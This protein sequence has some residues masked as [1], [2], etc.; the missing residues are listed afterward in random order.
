MP[1]PNFRPARS[2]RSGKANPAIGFSN[3]EPLSA[4]LSIVSPDIAPAAKL[5][6]PPPAAP[7][8]AS[9]TLPPAT[10]T[11]PVG[12][13]VPIRESAPPASITAPLPVM[14]PAK[15]DAAVPATVSVWLPSTIALP[16]PPPR[17]PMI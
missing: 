17:P 12:P 5:I 6:A 2:I 7:N 8:A 15:F 16:V 3:V 14:S 11:P 10:V 4:A 13:L 1:A 9:F